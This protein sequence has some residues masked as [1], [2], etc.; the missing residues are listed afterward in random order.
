MSD[1]PRFS[2]PIYNL[3]PTEIAGFD[4]R[5]Q[6]AL[7]M[8]CSW[9]HATDGVWRQLDPILWEITDNPWVVLQTLL[10]SRGVPMLLGGDEFRRTQGGNNN[11][12]CQDNE[13]SWHDWSYLEQHKA[14]F[15]FTSGMIAFRRARP[16]L[17]KE[18]FYTDAEIHWFSQQGGLPNWSDKEEKQFGCLIHEDEQQELCLMFNAGADA[19][20]FSLPPA[21]PGTRW[22]LAVDTS[23]EAPQDL[24]AA[25]EEPPSENPQT[26]HLS[27]QSSAVLLARGTNGQRF[28][29]A[30]PEAE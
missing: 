15:R 25:G 10:I 17:S 13:T 18:R 19:V 27:P 23:H 26:H 21:L 4:S 1:Q 24:F 20:N 29:T 14:N 30:L 2:H 9:N 7:D 22:H 28:Q 3:L 6:L 11:A 16:I 5:A 12:Y 8:H